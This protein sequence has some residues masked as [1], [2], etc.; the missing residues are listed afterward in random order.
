MA[1]IAPVVGRHLPYERR[2]VF[3][4][5]AAPQGTLRVAYQGEPGAFSETAVQ[6]FFDPA[7]TVPTPTFAEFFARARPWQVHCAVV[8]L[9]S[10]RQCSIHQNFDLL[11][12]HPDFTSTTGEVLLRIVHH[13]IANPG[14]E[15]AE[16]E[17]V[18]AHAQAAAQCDEYLPLPVLGGH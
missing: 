15:L 7:E 10:L 8:P 9:K 17:R 1:A 6:H 3:A 2:S 4:V 5:K 13:L 16:I 14:V 18:Y 12:E 11:L